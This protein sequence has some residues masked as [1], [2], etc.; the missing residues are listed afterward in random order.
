MNLFP[1]LLVAHIALA[2][3]LLLPS[4]V[5]PFILRGGREP[6]GWARRLLAVQGTGTLLIALG[7]A[8]TGAA[9]LTI[10]GPSLLRQPWLLVALSLYAI[11]LLVAGFISRPNLRRLIGI[12]AGDGATWRRRA[13]QQR[14][15]AY[16]MAAVI[17]AIGFLMSAKPQLW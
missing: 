11:N 7:L 9:M 12:G 1:V 14:Y 13:R 8:L 16:G 3:S 2:V 5:L 15:V 10:L 17:G 4:V 6:G